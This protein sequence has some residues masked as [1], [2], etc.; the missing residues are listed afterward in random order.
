MILPLCLFVVFWHQHLWFINTSCQYSERSGKA[1]NISIT[2][3]F[4]SILDGLFWAVSSK[5]LHLNV[6]SAI[7]GIGF[8]YFSLVV[9]FGG[10]FPH[11]TRA[12][13][14]WTFGTSKNRTSKGGTSG[15][16]DL[17]VGRYTCVIG[18]IHSLFW[19]IF[20]HP[21]FSDGIRK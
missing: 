7:L 2:S 18:S 3:T 21:T 14:T 4:R 5:S 15:I 17:F 13:R 19:G 1:F 6:F 11:P 20:T 10:F 12:G 8:P 16:D 9:P